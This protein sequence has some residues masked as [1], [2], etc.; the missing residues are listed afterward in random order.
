MRT[1]LTYAL[2]ASLLTLLA[3]CSSDSNSTGTPGDDL[4]DTHSGQDLA[5]DA[6]SDATTDLAQ[7]QTDPKETTTPDDLGL[8]QSVPPDTTLPDGTVTDQN[9]QDLADSQEEDTTQ[10]TEPSIQLSAP[11]TWQRG[12]VNFIVT[13]AVPQGQAHVQI[14]WHKGDGIQK[15]I[16]PMEGFGDGIGPFQTGT[17]RIVW[18]SMASLQ[19]DAQ[20]TVQANL[21]QNDVLVANSTTG[22]FQLANKP[23]RDRAALV[24]NTINGSTPEGI[25][26]VRP[27]VYSLTQ[28]F[29]Y[30]GT[31][32][33]P[34][35]SP[36]VVTFH[37]A[38]M[39]A[40]TSD[41]DSDQITFYTFGADARFGQTQSVATPG[42]YFDDI[43]W[44]G[45]GVTLY[46][47]D[48]NPTP[49]AGVYVMDLNPFTGLPQG[50]GPVHLTHHYAGNKLDLLPGNAGY[51]VAAGIE[52]NPGSGILLSLQNSQ[53]D[54]TGSYQLN[55]DGSIPSV[56]S[57]SPDGTQMLFGYY[58]LFG[59][60]DKVMLFQLPPEGDPDFIAEL[61]VFDPAD[62]EWAEDGSYIVLAEGQSD[63]VTIL[64][65]G[66][67]LALSK[68][69][70]F[71]L[72]L[73]Y[74][75]YSM[76]WGSQADQFMV[77]TVSGSTGISGIRM[78]TVLDGAFVDKGMFEFGDGMEHLIYSAGIQE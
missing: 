37:P 27:L 70:S 15:P 76:R 7:D 48:F 55:S 40:V 18:D 3:A 42:R 6:A 66:G 11:T 74:D 57:V 46:L 61:D 58:N 35:K 25:N 68:G 59:E 36:K 62:A 21:V 16:V 72:G 51:V 77:P 32:L 50:A 52:S 47:L 10:P 65:I 12:P 28:G 29:Q 43:A 41:Q 54:P 8:D 53:G 69:G 9:P 31:T 1:A 23:D 5:S 2:V 34:G 78:L 44:S 60:G 19:E 39:V 75:V 22:T 67:G 30:D 63:K 64:K 26:L 49:E 24:T 38:G 4:P 56:L 33:T 71:K 73:P 45:D 20:I 14:V 17:Y 13:V